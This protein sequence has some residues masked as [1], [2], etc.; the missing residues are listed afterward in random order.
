M[1]TTINLVTFCPHLNLLQYYWLYSIFCIVHPHDLFLTGSLCLLI[2]F[3]YFDHPPTLLL[4]GNPQFIFCIYESSSV[5]FYLF[6]CFVY[7]LFSIPHIIE[8]IHYFSFS[9]WHIS[10]SIT[11]SRS[12][13]VVA[14]GKISF[15]FKVEWY[16]ITYTNT[17]HILFNHS[18]IDGHF[19]CLHILAVVNNAAMNL[20]VHIPFW[21]S[22]YCSFEEGNVRVKFTLH[23]TQSGCFMGF[24]ISSHR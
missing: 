20:G 12:I 10:L 14:K 8:I 16:S 7:L 15:F 17:L 4:S 9:V 6:I 1:I 18:S 23:Q 19:S 21:I 13:L 3:T 11:L 5:L 24:S 22:V 2:P